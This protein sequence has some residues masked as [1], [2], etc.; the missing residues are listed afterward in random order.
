[1]YMTSMMTPCHN[2]IENEGFE[3]VDG[4]NGKCYKAVIDT[5]TNR[6]TW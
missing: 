2:L 4:I 5:L 3:I 6:K 1:M